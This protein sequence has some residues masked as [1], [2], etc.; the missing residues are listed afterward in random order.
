M[1]SICQEQQGLFS[2]EHSLGVDNIIQLLQEMGVQLIVVVCERMEVH[3]DVLLHCNVIHDVDEVQQSLRQEGT[4]C[5]QR[6]LSLLL[7]LTTLPFLHRSGSTG[8]VAVGF[9]YRGKVNVG[10]CSATPGK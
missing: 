1:A 4:L 8:W 9:S 10:K 6:T 2:H 5:W 3:Q 7:H